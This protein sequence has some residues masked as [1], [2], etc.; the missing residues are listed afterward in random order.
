VGIDRPDD[1]DEPSD[2]PSDRSSGAGD[3]GESANRHAAHFETRSRQEYY[4]DLRADLS[5]Q[6]KKPAEP[7]SAA[8]PPEPKANGKPW[9]EVT[10][11]SHR[12]WAQYQCK[13]P[14]EE[15]PPVNRSDDP[16]G[17]WRGDGNR[18]LVPATNKEIDQ[19]CGQI[20]DREKKR[21]SPALREIESRDPDRHLV[22]FEFHL[23]G[24]D[25][26][27]EKAFD[28]IKENG[29]SPRE[30][31]SLIPDT[32]RY[33][34]Q[35]DE[36]RYSQGVRADISRL[37]EQ[38]FR[39]VKLKNSWSEEQYKGV[40]SQWEEPAS[41]QLFELQFHTKISFEAKQITHSAYERLRTKQADE[42][43]EMVLETFQR[44]VSAEIP[45]P[46]GATEIPDYP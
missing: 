18:S 10:R 1:A 6:S 38:G 40:N 7:A 30:A 35:Y 32:I 13:W 39:L 36:T 45:I 26:I 41:G 31:V 19:E 8:E 23:K 28:G 46:P 12:V 44:K 9:E 14:P 5:E 15:R 16:P 2:E 43:E 29:L 33:T 11:W 34:F 20:S 25:R 21:I 22:G 3:D 4:D 42:L 17:S 24:R 27:K 37:E